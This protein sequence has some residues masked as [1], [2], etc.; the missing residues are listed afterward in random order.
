M[1]KRVFP[2]ESTFCYIAKRRVIPESKDETPMCYKY[3]QCCI[4]QLLEKYDV[5][6]LPSV[7][8]ISFGFILVLEYSLVMA[9]II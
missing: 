7:M 6:T 9:F 5:Y 1:I 3:V 4:E 8:H 2:Y